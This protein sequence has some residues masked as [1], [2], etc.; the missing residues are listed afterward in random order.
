M[1]SRRRP[2]S[3]RMLR[4]TTQRIFPKHSRELSVGVV[5]FR[6]VSGFR[7]VFPASFVWLPLVSGFAGP[8]KSL[9]FEPFSWLCRLMSSGVGFWRLFPAVSGAESGQLCTAEVP[10]HERIINPRAERLCVSLSGNEAQ[11]RCSILNTTHFSTASVVMA[12]HFAPLV[13]RIANT[14]FASANHAHVTTYIGQI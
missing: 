13:G 4:S 5:R 3:Q 7:V 11:L 8:T 9:C 2:L 1:R 14:H 12:S 10:H 6:L